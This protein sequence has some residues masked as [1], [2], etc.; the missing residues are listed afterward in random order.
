MGGRNGFSPV[1]AE[2]KNP[3]T[4]LPIQLI[5]VEYLGQPSRR[6]PQKPLKVGDKLSVV[7]LN[8][9]LHWPQQLRVKGRVEIADFAQKSG[10]VPRGEV[11]SGLASTLGPSLPAN[12]TSPDK[13]G[14]GFLGHESPQHDDI[15]VV[16]KKGR[17]AVAAPPSVGV[18]GC[19]G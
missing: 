16:L 10:E 4:L 5:S 14:D 9:G 3:V 7:G 2:F 1:T 13:A 18:R 11:L 12:V 19:V 8:S 15:D 17:S 6:R